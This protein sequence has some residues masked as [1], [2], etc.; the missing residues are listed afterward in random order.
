MTQLPGIS[1]SLRAGSFNTA[2]RTLGVRYWSAGRLLVSRAG[3][4]FGE[5]GKLRDDS[6]RVQLG[7]FVAGFAAFTARNA[8]R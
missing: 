4:A 3:Q 7:K 5:D 1:G 8:G 2:L 6:V